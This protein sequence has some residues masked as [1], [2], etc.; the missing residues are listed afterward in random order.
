MLLVMEQP[1]RQAYPTDVT[2]DE[3]AFVSP[4]LTL[5]R[6]D[7]HQRTHSLRNVFNALRWIVRAGAPWRMLPHDFPPW[8]AV[9]QQAQRWIA[10]EVFE[11]MVH[12]LRVLLRVAS[13]RERQPTAVILDGRT[14]QSTP[15][16]GHRAGYDGAKKRKGSKTHIA[17]D[18][19]GA[20][21]AVHVTPASEQER[22]QVATLAAEV[23]GV[24]GEHSRSRLWIKATPGSR[25]RQTRQSTASGW[26]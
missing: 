9:Y 7:A 19:L 11:T 23:Q 5:M 4:Y 14:L 18:T 8:A 22:A 16:S 1:Q 15:E 26:R 2:D 13:G 10:A 21:L 17:V 24:T 20:L 25:R 3:W 6:E 12:D